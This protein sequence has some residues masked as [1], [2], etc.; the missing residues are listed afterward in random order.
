L[1]HPFGFGF[2]QGF[3]SSIFTR[4]PAEKYQA[5]AGRKCQKDRRARS[6]VRSPTIAP[7]F[8]GLQRNHDHFVAGRPRLSRQY[9]AMVKSL[10]FKGLRRFAGMLRRY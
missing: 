9:N 6:F 3:I 8:G 10:I 7:P 4:R 2:Q 1:F 5:D